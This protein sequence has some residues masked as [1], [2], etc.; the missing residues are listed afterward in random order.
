[1]GTWP[2]AQLRFDRLTADK[3]LRVTPDESERLFSR[4]PSPSWVGAG[5][6][7]PGDWV[8]AGSRSSHMCRTHAVTHPGTEM[9]WWAGWAIIHVYNTVY[10]T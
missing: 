5:R 3:P 9:T 4:T 10:Y 2:A 6:V 1:M 7:L 8:W